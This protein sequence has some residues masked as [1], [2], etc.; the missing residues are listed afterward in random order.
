MHSYQASLH[1]LCPETKY[2]VYAPI[3]FLGLRLIVSLA[4]DLIYLSVNIHH[5]LSRLEEKT[6]AVISTFSWG[7]NLLSH[8]LFIFFFGCRLLVQGTSSTR[9]SF[10]VKLLFLTMTVVVVC[11][12][13]RRIAKEEWNYRDGCE[14]MSFC[15]IKPI[16][17]H[18]CIYMFCFYAMKCGFTIFWFI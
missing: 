6:W 9:M 8:N 4:Q 10:I 12:Q 14:R 2:S 7:R 11:G 1:R 16:L 5:L 13:R 3:L 18:L 15:L 17:V